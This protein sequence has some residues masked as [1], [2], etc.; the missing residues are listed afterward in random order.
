MS[1]LLRRHV[2]PVVSDALADTRVVAVVGALRTFSW[3]SR[4][5]LM[6]TRG[7]GASS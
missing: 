3:P 7:R 2:D 5:R 6:M 1:R 4:L